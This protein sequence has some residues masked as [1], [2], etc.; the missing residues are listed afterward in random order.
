[1]NTFRRSKALLAAFVLLGFLLAAQVQSPRQMTVPKEASRER[2]AGTIARLEEEQR[3]LKE[4]IGR[5]REE[6]AVQQ[7]LGLARSESLREINSELEKQRLA[8]GLLPLKGQGVTV[9]LD[10]SSKAVGAGG[11]P[12]SYLVHDYELRDVINL[13]W[14]SGA[15]AVAV[16]DERLAGG[17][18]IYC[19]GSTIL[20]NNT[21]LSP[22]YEI[23][24]I[25]DAVA[26]EDR[27]RN[28]ASLAKLKSRARLYGI[29]FRVTSSKE[30]TLPAYSSGFSLR[31]SSPAKD[32]G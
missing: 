18:S 2:V 11:D 22:P 19:V 21:R 8:A 7:K 20:V 25:G 31:Y 6:L 10:D 4:T 3:S 17:T 16:N 13:L 32:G 14:A 30:V 27:L 24:A 26:L 23:R 29:Q 28:P 15:E 9:T 5:L 12:A 1:M